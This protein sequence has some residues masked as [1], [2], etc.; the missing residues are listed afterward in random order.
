M[1]LISGK[2]PFFT[3][4]LHPISDCYIP[5]EWDQNQ[6]SEQQHEDRIHCAGRQYFHSH[7]PD[8]KNSEKIIKVLWL[9]DL[10]SASFY[11]KTTNQLS[12]L[13]QKKLHIGHWVDLGYFLSPPYQFEYRASWF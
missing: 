3:R 2:K 4:W 8:P 6:K 10:S 12:N 7:A 13:L 11:E 9:Y 5:G 1:N